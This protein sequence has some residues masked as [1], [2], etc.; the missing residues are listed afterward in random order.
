M[1]IIGAIKFGMSI[2][3]DGHE[4]M[5]DDGNHFRI[6]EEIVDAIVIVQQFV[7][8][9]DVQEVVGLDKDDVPCKAWIVTQL[10]EAI[11]LMPGS[12]TMLLLRRRLGGRTW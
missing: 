5:L 12:R 11:T 4:M 9:V 3:F 7:E 10:L 8:R 2:I 6:T 1:K